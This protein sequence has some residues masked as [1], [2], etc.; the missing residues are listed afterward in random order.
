MKCPDCGQRLH[1]IP[2]LG[3][4]EWVCE[5]SACPANKDK[6]YAFAEYYGKTQKEVNAQKQCGEE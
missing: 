1:G 4:E 6:S 3:K 2:P 5:N